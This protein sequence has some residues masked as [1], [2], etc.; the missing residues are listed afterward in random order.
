M[1]AQEKEVPG[2]INIHGKDYRTVALRVSSFRE[3]HK[4]SDGWGI[5]TDVQEATQDHCK[6]KATIVDPDGRTIAIGHAE[7]YKSDMPG[8][9]QSSILEV[10]ETSAVGRALAFAGY[11][12]T[13]IATDD[14]IQRTGNLCDMTKGM[15]TKY[16]KRL[17]KAAEDGDGLALGETWD[18][19]DTEERKYIW[20]EL[21]SD[22]KTLIK[23]GLDEARAL[24]EAPDPDFEPPA[25]IE[26]HHKGQKREG[27]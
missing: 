14:D 16:I 12:G 15:R 2:V 10:C 26:S 19:L 13:E 20:A 23:K 22:E 5:Y 11:G 21:R 25:E 3:R 24:A 1:S 18:E 6:V 17:K 7:E 27:K 8:N 9:M 4:T